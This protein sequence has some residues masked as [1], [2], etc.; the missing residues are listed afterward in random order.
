MSNVGRIGVD[1]DEVAA[2]AVS[3][4]HAAAICCVHA[5]GVR[6][7]R[8]ARQS[9]ARGVPGLIFHKSRPDGA[10]RIGSLSSISCACRVSTRDP[11]FQASQSFPK[12]ARTAQLFQF[13]RQARGGR[14]DRRR[15][16]P[17]VLSDG[18]ARAWRFR[19]LHPHIRLVSHSLHARRH[20][21]R[22]SLSPISPGKGV[23]RTG[24]Y[25]VDVRQWLHSR[26]VDACGREKNAA[27][28]FALQTLC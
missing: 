4:G 13:C 1:L 25:V 28:S 2:R 24:R 6:K 26:R 21:K 8:M 11:I 23:L 12:R 15:R 18:A 10:D 19:V 5:V 3:C 22:S 14:Y 20:T 16:R 7:A 27:A 9:R 17:V